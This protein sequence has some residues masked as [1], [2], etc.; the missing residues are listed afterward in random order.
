MKAEKL[1]LLK[2]LKKFDVF[3]ENPGKVSNYEHVIEMHN[4][5][6]FHAPSYPIAFV[7]SVRNPIKEMLEWEIIEPGVTE[8]VSPLVTVKKKDKSV[9]ICLDARWL[10]KRMSKD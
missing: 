1:H 5:E 2:F 10:N 7:H 3:S 4:S 6:P 9:R 8:Y